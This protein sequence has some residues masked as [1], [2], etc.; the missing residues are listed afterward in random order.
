MGIANMRRPTFKISSAGLCAG[1]VAQLDSTS[2]TLT[3]TR[4]GVEDLARVCGAAVG[5]TASATRLLPRRAHTLTR[6]AAVSLSRSGAGGFGEAWSAPPGCRTREAR[7]FPS[8]GCAYAFCLF[9][10][11]RT[12]EALTELGTATPA[13]LS[14][15]C[16]AWEGGKRAP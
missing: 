3:L 8:L 12:E 10:S 4:R 9:W 7:T 14:C 6:R 11:V 13:A 2:R 1:A 5:D 15:P 16:P